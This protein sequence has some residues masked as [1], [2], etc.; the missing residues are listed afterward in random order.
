MN[1]GETLKGLRRAK[2]MTQEQLSEYL[3]VTAQA[4]SKWETGASLPDIT[5]VPLLSNIFDVSADVLLGIDVSEKGKRI[6]EI[7]EHAKK[8]SDKGR[9]GE[10]VAILRA[11]LR[12]YPG[13]H[14]LMNRLA[15]SLWTEHDACSPETRAERIKEVIG[16]GETILAESTDDEL[17]HDAIQLLCYTYPEAGETEK[18][19]ALAKKMPHTF[20]SS[21][22]L[23]AN[24]Y[25]GDKRFETKRKNLFDSIGFMI[26]DMSYNAAPLDDGGRPFT[27]EEAIAVNKK[28]VALLNLMFEDGKFG[29]YGSHMARTYTLLAVFCARTKACDDAVQY[30][31][32]AAE[33]AVRADTEYDPDEEYTCLL[34]RGM[35]FGGVAFSKAENESLLLLKDMDDPDFDF[36]RARKDFIEVEEFLKP[37]A[38]ER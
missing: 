37:Y 23:L 10:A 27:A 1:F 19:V 12:E 21:Q 4:V 24:I 13:S 6:Q 33:Q 18:A 20:L 25:S 16:L 9:H 36:I 8:L 31:K 3:N 17:R 28:S 30:L 11:G 15:I 32:L 29:Y 38:K 35:K 14:R 2:D 7:I 5:L 26:L 22:N 34:F